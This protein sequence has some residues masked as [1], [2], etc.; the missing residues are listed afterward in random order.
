M[1]IPFSHCRCH[2]YYSGAQCGLF[3][4]EEHVEDPNSKNNRQHI[5][6][7]QVWSLPQER[8]SSQ[9]PRQNGHHFTDCIF[10]C[11]FCNENVWILISLKFF[12]NCPINNIP[13]LV[14]IMAW[15]QP[16]DKLLSEPMMVSSLTHICVTGPQWVNTVDDVHRDSIYSSD[17]W[18]SVLMG[19]SL[20]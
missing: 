5:E 11:I 8:P 19:I 16:G 18:H 3:S 4:P 14:Q 1:L 10:K 17:T 9:K 6:Q 7:G 20:E 13:A 2:Q 15:H 12:P